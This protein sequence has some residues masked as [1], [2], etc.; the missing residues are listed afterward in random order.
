MYI[1]HFVYTYV[2]GAWQS[3]L[4]TAFTVWQIQNQKQI[5]KTMLWWETTKNNKYLRKQYHWC[6]QKKFLALGEFFGVIKLF[7]RQVLLPASWVCKFWFCKFRVDVYL[8]FQIYVLYMYKS[9]LDSIH[10]LTNTESEANPKTMLWWENQACLLSPHIN[11]HRGHD[12]MPTF[13]TIRFVLSQNTRTS[14]SLFKT[15][16]IWDFAFSPSTLR[17][18]CR[19]SFFLLDL[20]LS[21]GPVLILPA[22]CRPC[23]NFRIK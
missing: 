2:Y 18:H 23:W 15:W 11:S 20:G 6:S 3:P 12:L 21:L 7:C 19:I 17:R 13:R 5:P 9:S 16:N 4:S 14:A 10:C 22:F 1:C 8:Q